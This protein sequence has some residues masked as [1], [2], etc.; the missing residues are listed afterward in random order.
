M[1]KNPINYQNTIIYKIVCND[2][3]IKD[4][5]VGHTTDFKRRKNEHKNSCTNV[6]NKTNLK[7]YEF[8][9]NNGGWKNWSM[10]EL[11]KF[12]CND[13][14]EANTKEREYFE[15]LNATL[16]SI[17]PIL[18]TTE[19]INQCKKYYSNNRINILENKLEYYNNNKYKVQ[20]RNKEPINC[21]CGLTITKGA[22][23]NHEKSKKHL[24]NLTNNIEV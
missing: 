12:A 3:N 5:Y 2:L 19:R 24:K 16:N 10:I 14:N 11:E 20:S 4:C 8:I 17:I 1:P 18:D 7:V 13:S 23:Y 15:F 21:I 6:T 9:R 22:K